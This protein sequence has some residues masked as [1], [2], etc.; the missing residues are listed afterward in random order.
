MFS[1]LF[2]LFTGP[3][4][5]IA[6][7]LK[8]A[9]L[10]KQDAKTE[11]ER[12]AA[13]ERISH[14][15]ARKAVILAAQSDPVERFV[16]IAWALPMVLYTW[17]LIIWDKILQLGSTDNLSPDLWNI[18]MIVLAGYFIDVTIRRIKS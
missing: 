18:Y 11:Q 12:I 2:S 9:Y 3:L 17:K 16:R 13:E 1:W 7:E 14:L 8:E 15:E 5:T 10:A 6:K 4:G